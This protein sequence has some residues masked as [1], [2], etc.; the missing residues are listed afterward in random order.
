MELEKFE[1]TKQGLY[2]KVHNNNITKAYRKLK[3]LMR[4]EGIDQEFRRRQCYEKPSVKRKR[5]K[6]IG[7]SRWQKKQRET[8]DNW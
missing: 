7:R 3:R 4:D 2:V 5:L 1:F 6:D 8:K